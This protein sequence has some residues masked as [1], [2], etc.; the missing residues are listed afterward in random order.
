[1]LKH[2][3][4]VAGTICGVAALAGG[5][6]VQWNRWQPKF[7]LPAPSVFTLPTA[8][9]RLEQQRATERKQLQTALDAATKPY[10]GHVS[11]VVTDLKSD[12]TASVAPNDQMVSASLYKMY[13]GW[14]IYQ[15]IDQGSLSLAS[16]TP[17]GL[18][19]GQCMYVMITVSDNDCG[20]TLGNMVGWANLDTKLAAL[21]LTQ[22]KINNY[23]KGVDLVGDKLTSAAD[24]ALFTQ[25]L[26]EG[27]LLSP[28]N[29]E[30]YMNLLKADELNTWL[31]SGLPKGTPIAHKTGALY[32]L[33]HDAGV[34]YSPNGD[35]LIVV[36][37]RG[38]DNPVTQPPAVFA[39]ISRQLWNFFA[40]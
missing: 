39:D 26:Y 25:Q 3:A 19:V 37:S 18:T 27:K 29:T 16:K 40:I 4:L 11:V 38:W 34:V 22:T 6:S 8:A 33:V 14:A 30:A 9:E 7:E 2:K 13:V 23:G 12:V 20:Y 5:L 32:D 10:A 1:M 17:R 24:V 31:P 15:K 35:Y 21:G 28:H 36:M